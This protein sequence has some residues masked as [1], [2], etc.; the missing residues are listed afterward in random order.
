MTDIP[1]RRYRWWRIAAWLM[2]SLFA[3]L[4]LTLI[5]GAWWLY[6]W[7]WGRPSFHESWTEE[8][9]AALTEFDTYL[10][11]SFAGDLSQVD[12]LFSDENERS[13]KR[14]V[15]APIRRQLQDAAKNGQGATPTIHYT[16]GH[17]T[18]RESCAPA[19]VASQTGHL[20]ALRALIA[21]GA[22]PNAC[23]SI[24]GEEKTEEGD[25]P[26]S[27]LLSGSFS[28]NKVQIPWSER[29]EMAEFLLSRGADL[30]AHSSIIGLCCNLAY[31]RGESEPWLWALE[32]GKKVS[33]AELVLALSVNKLHL[34]LIEAMLRST[35]EI[36]NA[37][38]GDDTPLQALAKR[39]RYADEEEMPALEQVLD[40]LLAHGANPS[41]RPEPKDEYD[42]CE[43]RL[44]LD[45]LLSKSNF[46][47][48]GMEGDDCEGEG[49]DVRTIWERMCNKLQQSS[50]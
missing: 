41:L 21:H 11:N 20:G 15:S 45:I 14:K 1:K 5:A 48:C 44:P 25:T 6:G 19:I 3:L 35:P 34:P 46:A 27:C 9:R 18:F 40:L 38:D 37:T 7:Q 30:N 13:L 28:P 42:S 24:E 50:L 49:D 16:A 26:M 31:M 23:I 47:T 12:I 36:A 39:I 8:E 22:D 17:L 2:S 4:L 43:R 32:H 10:R 33:G 29:K